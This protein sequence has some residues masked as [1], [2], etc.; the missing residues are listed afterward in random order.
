MKG[1]W[2]L[3]SIVIVVSATVGVVRLTA[4]DE[5]AGRD[6]RCERRT[7]LFLDA[8]ATEERI[9]AVGER[10][11][12]CLSDDDGATWRQVVVPTKATLTGL[13]F[14]DQESG[15]AVGHQTTVLRTVDGGMSWEEAYTGL[16]ESDPLFDIWFRDSKYGFAIGAFGLLLT[17]EDGGDSWKY[18]RIDEEELHLYGISGGKDGVPYVVGERG[19]IYRLTEG[20]N[21]WPRFPSPYEG[22]LFGLFFLKRGSSVLFGL[23]GHLFFREGRTSSWTEIEAGVN[24]SFFGGQPLRGG[25]VVLGGRRGTLL[26]FSDMREAPKNLSNES[27]GNVTAVVEAESGSLLVFGDRGVHRV[28]GEDN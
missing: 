22:S 15:W 27:Y 11:T 3:L 9:I 8:H 7:T 17:T 4:A 18:G 16:R 14:L 20:T 10:G 12:L 1:T 24:E 2:R 19:E 25:G 21:E 13:F 26:L 5:S 28:T 23:N 6:P